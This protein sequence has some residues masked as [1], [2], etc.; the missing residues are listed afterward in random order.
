MIKTILTLNR[1]QRSPSA[2]SVLISFKFWERSYYQ[3]FL[4]FHK[5]FIAITFLVWSPNV[6]GQVFHLINIYTKSRN[7]IYCSELLLHPLCKLQRS[8]MLQNGQLISK[9]LASHVMQLQPLFLHLHLQVLK[10]NNLVLNLPHLHFYIKEFYQT[11][12]PRITLC[13][14]IC[15]RKFTYLNLNDF[16]N[17]FLQLLL[18]FLDKSTRH[19]HCCFKSFNS[20]RT[21][22]ISRFYIGEM[23]FLHSTWKENQFNLTTWLLWQ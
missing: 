14:C 9:K 1:S 3:C 6:L 4:L 2:S 7:W 13:I 18:F 22:C 8:L 16:R 19:W 17:R 5:S 23:L 21:I 20:C 10:P 12:H 11:S 15:C